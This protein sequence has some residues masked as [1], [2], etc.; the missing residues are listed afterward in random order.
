MYILCARDECTQERARDEC[1]QERARDQCTRSSTC[2]RR[3]QKTFSTFPATPPAPVVSV[4]IAFVP[5]SGNGFRDQCARGPG[6]AAHYLYRDTQGGGGGGGVF[7]GGQI[8][9]GTMKE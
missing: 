2:R 3:V 1:T 9:Y 7:F 4:V 8:Q 5:A 6:A